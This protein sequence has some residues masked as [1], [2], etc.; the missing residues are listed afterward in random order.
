MKI[1]DFSDKQILVVGLGVSGYAAADLL[2]RKGAEVRVTEASST[3]E[4][5]ERAGKLSAWRVKTELGEHTEDFCRGVDMVVTSPGIDDSALPLS[6]ARSENVPIIGELELG[7][8][9]CRGRVIAITGTNGK[10]TTTE[11]IGKILE[12]SG[13]HVVVCGN[14]G[15]PI[16][17]EVDSI[18]EKSV[19]VVEVS[20]F[21]LART[22][23]FKPYIAVLLNI[24]ED[25][26][27]RHGNFNNYKKDKFR[28]FENQTARDWAVIYSELREDPMVSEIKSRRVFFGSS[29]AQATASSEGISIFTRGEKEMIMS[30]DELPIKGRHNL[31]NAASA[32][33]VA[34]IMGVSLSSARKS[35]M[36]FSAL[37]HRFESV[38][39][40]SGVEFIDDSKATN[41]DA[42]KRALE[43][44]DRKVVLIAGGRDKGG[45]Y[46]SVL[47]VV[48][49]KVKAVVLLGE[50][51]DKIRSVFRDTVP[52]SL[53]DDMSDAVRK[54]FKEASQ[55]EVVMLSPMCSSFDM[56]SS[57]KER[58]EVFQ[59]EV[60]KIKG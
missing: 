4:V 41:I 48:K 15:N 17:G 9:F 56:F 16:T 55:G 40:I 38:R 47:P 39:L 20:S 14:I 34:D 42:T 53:A 57:Y 50:A 44:T 60:N 43:S 28:I 32:V 51:S 13:A 30:Y 54:A 7:F 52:V 21:Q 45:D 26:Y 10:S 25:H 31:E 58:G 12:D 27:E 19:V 37:A 22:R 2:V 1:T 6:L 24:T 3:P 11:L 59:E 46:R 5:K 8:L 23:T 35:I 33:L 49:E 29:G 36:E 18:T